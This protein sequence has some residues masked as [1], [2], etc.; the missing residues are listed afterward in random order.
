MQWVWT[1]HANLGDADR[2]SSFYPGA[3]FVDWVSLTVF[4]WGTTLAW[5]EWHS[6]DDLIRPTYDALLRFEK[7]LMISEIGTVTDGG[8]A[9]AW[10]SRAM[11]RLQVDYARVRAVVWFSYRYSRWADFRLRGAGVSALRLALASGY[12]HGG[13]P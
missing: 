2:L 3:A 4:N 10:I 12:W 1:V 6:L 5:S 13:N 8:S 11:E 7:P 9:A